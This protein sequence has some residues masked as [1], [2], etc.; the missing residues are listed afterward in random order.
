VPAFVYRAR[1]TG[2]QFVRGKADAE[3]E[4]DLVARLRNQGML[5]L[6]VDRDMDLQ[7]MMNRSGSFLS[8]KITGRDL[9][10][11]SRQF[12]TMINAGLPVVT[13]LKVLGRQSGNPR[14]Q[15]ALEHIAIDVESGESLA[16]A[17]ARRG[18]AFPT[19]M[20]QMIGAGEVGGILDEVLTRLAGQLEKEEAIRQKVRS[21]MVY[22]TIVSVVAVLV[23]IFLMI[24][25]VPKFVSVYADLGAD[26][27]MATKALMAVS[28]VVSRF[29]WL[30]A[31]VVVGGYVGLR[32]WLKT[33]VGALAWDR[34][35][36]KVPIFGQLVTKQCIGRFARTLGGLLSSGISILKAL[37]VV[38]RT[39]GNRVIAAAV[40][41]ALEEVRQGQNL[42]VPLRRSGV[43]PSMVLEMITVGEE[44]G[45]VEEMLVKVADFYE[46]EVQRMAEQLSSSLEPVIIVGLA[47]TVGFIVASMMMPIFNLWSAFGN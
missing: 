2:G 4:K 29:W 41:D 18:E 8:R 15:N 26:L 25:V 28:D 38:E 35:M 20:V 16:T 7:V 9:A 21:A 10:L 6:G 33:E 30:M 45:T 13:A 11:F 24:F 44:T 34:F 5:V 17:F 36:L 37:A 22:P 40:R 42:V 14:M 39:V 1:D 27:P 12:S 47:V 43:F 46:D 23:V 31:A 3:T 32:A 19:V